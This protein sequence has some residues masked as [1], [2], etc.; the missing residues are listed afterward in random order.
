MRTAAMLQRVVECPVASELCKFI[1]EKDRRAEAVLPFH[2][3]GQSLECRAVFLAVD[4]LGRFLDS[5]QTGQ[6]IIH[7]YHFGHIPEGDA[8]LAAVEGRR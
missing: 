1:K 5:K 2:L 4:F 7:V 8:R 6:F 3:G